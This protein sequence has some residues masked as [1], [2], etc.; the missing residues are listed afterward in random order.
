MALALT[1]LDRSARGAVL[2]RPRTSGTV[3][4]SSVVPSGKMHAGA[5]KTP[6]A[7]RWKSRRLALGAMKKKEPK[8]TLGTF[9]IRRRKRG[10]RWAVMAQVFSWCAHTSRAG[11]TMHTRGCDQKDFFLF[12]HVPTLFG[13]FVLFAVPTI[14]HT[15]P[16][17]IQQ[18]T[19]LA[20]KLMTR[21]F[22]SPTVLYNS[23]KLK[24]DQFWLTEIFSSYSFYFSSYTF[25]H[26]IILFME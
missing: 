10:R 23:I 12:L 15:I 19:S 5:N 26:Y 8:P 11:M 6:H 20:A 25:F 4:S 22:E 9:S 17:S 1:L 3:R 14:D 18:V 24:L 13:R 21:H 2:Y 16:C 7:M